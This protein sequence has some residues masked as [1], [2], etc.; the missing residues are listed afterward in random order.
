MFPSN[1]ITD[2]ST[3]V[4]DPDVAIEC[5][6]ADEKRDSAR[7]LGTLN[8]QLIGMG[9]GAPVCCAAENLSEGGLYVCAA[10]SCGL[11]VGQRYEVALAEGARSPDRDNIVGEGC[12]A[13]VV[14]T[15][16]LAQ[17]SQGLIGAGLRFDQPLL[18]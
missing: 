11:A 9:G 1:A 18:L 4:A 8:A 5:A 12:Y 7:A 16:R 10:E 3:A 17:G 13:T 15:E 14:R 2:A 6:R